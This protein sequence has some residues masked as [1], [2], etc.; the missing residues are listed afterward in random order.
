MDK[1]NISSAVSLH[2]ASG[3]SSR[4]DHAMH[5]RVLGSAAG[6]GY[7]QWNCNHPNSARARAGDP[8]APRRTQSSIAVSADGQRFLN[9]AQ[10]AI[11][12]ADPVNHAA[13][14]AAFGKLL[15][16]W[17]D[18]RFADEARLQLGIQRLQAGDAEGAAQALADRR[19]VVR[20][21]GPGIAANEADDF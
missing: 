18:S 12:S 4:V 3:I 5:V 20:D 15:D 7:P 17:P 21:H 6:G 8:A 9:A 16:T 11:D 2:K 13:A 1:F 19:L 10:T 14:A